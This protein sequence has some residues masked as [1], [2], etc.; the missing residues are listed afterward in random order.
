MGPVIRPFWDMSI[1]ENLEAFTNGANVHQL[2]NILQNSFTMVYLDWWR[3]NYAFLVVLMMFSK[4]T[5]LKS[6]GRLSFLPGLF[7]INE[8]VF[9]ERLS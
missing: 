8:P 4:S 3:W 9:L 6:L 7:N 5:Y 1:A 2:P